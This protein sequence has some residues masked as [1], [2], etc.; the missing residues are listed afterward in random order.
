MHEEFT[1]KEDI[2]KVAITSF[3]TLSENRDYMKN[4]LSSHRF[5]IC[6]YEFP[7]IDLSG[8]TRFSAYFRRNTR[9]RDTRFLVFSLKVFVCKLLVFK[10]ILVWIYSFGEKVL[11]LVTR[12]FKEYS[13]NLL[14]F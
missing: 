5:I 6:Y 1:V 2:A 13:A 4:Q 14:V 8:I 3:I 11:V 12:F 7:D 9:F 10:K